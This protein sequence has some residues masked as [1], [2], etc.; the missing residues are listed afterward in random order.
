[1]ANITQPAGGRNSVNT[2]IAKFLLQGS[3][4][5]AFSPIFFI[6]KLAS[7]PSKDL[8]SHTTSWTRFLVFWSAESPQPSATSFTSS[9]TPKTPGYVSP[10][11]LVPTSGRIRKYILT[12]SKLRLPRY[13]IKFSARAPGQWTLVRNGWDLERVVASRGPGQLC[14]K[15]EAGILPWCHVGLSLLWKYLQ[16]SPPLTCASSLETNCLFVAFLSFTLS[17]PGEAIRPSCWDHFMAK[18]SRSS[19]YHWRITSWGRSSRSIPL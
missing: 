15:A 11:D 3:A 12:C 6:R 18:S 1:M 16:L 19:R 9:S 2:Q 10:R 7:I 5:T 13:I 4:K 8:A 14:S 17:G